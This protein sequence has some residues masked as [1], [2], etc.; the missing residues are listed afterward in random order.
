M[1]IDPKTVG[2]LIAETAV[3]TDT[4]QFTVST[5]R[6]DVGSYSTIVFDDSDD[7]R[8]HGMR[9]GNYWIVGWG[10]QSGT[11]DGALA[12]HQEAVDAA[13]TEKPTE[14]AT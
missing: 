2:D 5:V 3:V 8:H 4:K 10:Q 12:Q 9:L 14:R 1:N 11:L 13:Y 6:I 7:K